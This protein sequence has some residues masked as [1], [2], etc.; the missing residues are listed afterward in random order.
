MESNGDMSKTSPELDGRIPSLV[1]DEYDPESL[2]IDEIAEK[3][4]VRKLD[5][6]IVPMVMLLYLLVWKLPCVFVCPTNMF[7]VPCSDVVLS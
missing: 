5:L 2:E 3:K 6:Y 4:L 7:R 1:S